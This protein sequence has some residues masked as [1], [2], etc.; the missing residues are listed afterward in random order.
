MYLDIFFEVHSKLLSARFSLSLLNGSLVR[1]L[2]TSENSS[3]FML[4]DIY[5]YIQE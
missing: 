3:K 4:L 1:I 5:L 2:L